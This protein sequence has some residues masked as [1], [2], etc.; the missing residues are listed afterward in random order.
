MS[1]DDEV[2]V[3]E[4]E[5]DE[6][7]E[8]EVDEVD[9]GSGPSWF[10]VTTVASAI[11][12]LLAAWWTG[13]IVVI[14]L[15]VVAW[16]VA[17]A[18]SGR[19][20]S[21]RVW[22]VCVA[23]FVIGGAATVLTAGEDGPRA[24]DVSVRPVEHPSDDRFY[25]NLQ[26]TPG[27]RM[28]GYLNETDGYIAMDLQVAVESHEDDPLDDVTLELTY[29]SDV[30]VDSLGVE[31]VDPTGETGVYEHRLGTIRPGDPYPAME[32]ADLLQ[33]PV[34]FSFDE[35][36][37]LDDTEM[38]VCSVLTWDSTMGEVR[39]ECFS[40]EGVVACATIQEKDP[41]PPPSIEIGFVVRANGRPPLEGTF[42]ITLDEAEPST[43]MDA[44]HKVLQ[45]TSEDADWDAPAVAADFGP[46]QGE[47]ID[48]WSRPWGRS[49]HIVS[50]R[51]VIT[52]D[53]EV[54]QELSVDGVLRK[55]LIGQD[56]WVGQQIT[57][58]DGSPEADVTKHFARFW[59]LAWREAD[60]EGFADP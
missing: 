19:R 56:N 43:T 57:N 47:V 53:G 31:K 17:A 50:Y 5:V 22:A 2:E 23:I 29:P 54:H 10:D 39:Q 8:V 18:V 46:V 14:P 3:D 13:S 49:P 30:P 24:L 36:C 34:E 6:V 12:G 45:S 4:V 42:T 15:A 7:D 58:I 21:P 33:V 37:Y 48:E 27:Q 52:A 28:A 1:E 32:Q 9:D 59:M 38:P 55:V 60:F 44:G 41:P 26:P 51:K 25:E 20:L 16:I 11:F 35:R 40:I